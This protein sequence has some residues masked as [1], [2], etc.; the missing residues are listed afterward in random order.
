M[1]SVGMQVTK[2][3]CRSY[4]MH[5]ICEV[6][7]MREVDE[8]HDEVHDELRE[9]CDELHELRRMSLVLICGMMHLRLV[10]RLFS[11]QMQVV[12]RRALVLLIV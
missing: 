2:H 4:D 9:I 12:Y 5:E 8:V 10:K 6:H 3:S 7:E 11:W 1:D